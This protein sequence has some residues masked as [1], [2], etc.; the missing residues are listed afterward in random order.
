MNILYINHYAGSPKYGMEYR[1]YYM[2]KA[3]QQMGHRV[4]MAAAAFSHIR[5][6][7]PSINGEQINRKTIEHIDGI[8]YVWYPAPEY[9]GNGIGRLKNI[10]TFLWGLW[11]DT[12]NLLETAKPDVVI[13]SST[14]PM[15]I[16]V[17][18]H[19]AK[20]AK[21]KLIFEVHDLWP[22]SPIELGGMSPK[23]PFIMLCQAAENYAYKHADEVVSMLPKVHEHMKEHGLDLNKLYIIPNGVVEEDWLPENTQALPNSRLN[24]FLLEQQSLGKLIVGYA[25]SH[26]TSN[27]LEHFIEAA[28]LLE[29]QGVVF[30]L[31]GSGLE[32]KNLQEKTQYLQINNVHFFDSIPKSQIPDLLKYF[33]LAY[34]A[35]QHS[36]LYRFGVSPNKLM[37]YMMATKPILCA[38]KA[39]NDPVGDE[40]CGIT[41]E[42]GNPQAIADGIIVL[43]KL[44]KE[45]R[46]AMGQRGREF[47]LK[48]QTYTVLANQFLEVMKK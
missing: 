18:H 14:Y 35:A 33:D 17:A 48:N 9:D 45:E 21:A 24:D 26:G 38:I 6:K 8:D 29:K 4:T 22:L 44:S 39:G 31:V 5:T 12:S 1:P 47:I 36:P 46:L 11:R 42:P 41:V 15:D 16:W 10:F 28:K 27:A 40:Q 19:F 7:Q 37:D 25:G 34:I 3:W 43:A 13:A 23:H 30:V 32:K 2:A 20:K